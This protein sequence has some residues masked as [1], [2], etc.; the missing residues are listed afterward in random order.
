MARRSPTPAPAS[1]RLAI[2]A[3]AR[4][5]IDTDRLGSHSFDRILVFDCGQTGAAARDEATARAGA[6]DRALEQ[7]ADWIF[8]L[9]AGE[10]FA[11]DAL[12]QL[13]PAM[14]CRDVIWGA[15]AGLRKA[16][17]H[18]TI[19][20]RSL[21]PARS[22]LD[23]FH[24]ALEWWVGRSHL[25]N[26][27]AARE[28]AIDPERGEA[29][30]ADYLLRQWTR[31]RAL[32]SGVPLT[33]AEQVGGLTAAERACLL[34]RLADEPEWMTVEDGGRT[35]QLPYTGRNPT[36]ERVQMRRNFYEA[37]EL[38]TVARR[39]GKGARIVDVGANTG[40]HTV[41]FAGVMLA[42]SVLALEPNPETADI[43]AG[44]I[45]RNALSSVD[46]GHL[47]VAIGRERGRAE[48]VV[49]RRGHLG[50]ATITATGDGNTAVEPLDA[51]VDGPVDLIKIDV[52]DR[53]L[54][55]LAGARETIARHHPLILV[56]VRDGNAGAFVAFLAENGY[57][58]EEVFPDQGYA[59]Y[60]VAQS[61]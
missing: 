44:T 1:G 33:T 55:V 3:A 34:A 32:K 30:Y 16:A 52:E 26:R 4:G 46:L 58:V 15:L 27:E 39:L 7:G 25:I 50:T 20:P 38:R 13:L 10:N 22:R 48:I 23:A 9:G 45:A 8:H 42:R 43:L 29:W 24:M 37:S 28:I 41:Y 51:I 61:K 53:E 60:L 47:G 56:E 21:F 59:N 36:I 14:Q 49:G 35:F 5:P 18:A 54:D 11:P 12:T 6:V 2:I 40:N 17:E 31:G 57:K 19:F